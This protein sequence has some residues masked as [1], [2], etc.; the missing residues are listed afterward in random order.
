MGIWIILFIAGGILFIYFNIR[1]CCKFNLT[2]SFIKIYINIKI[3][4]KEHITDK[5]IY[6]TDM[7]KKLSGRYS[8]YKELRA[9][10]YYPYLKYLK[11][12][13]QLFIVKNIHLYP[14]CLDNSS[15][16]AVEFM[17]VNNIIKRPLIKG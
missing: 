14:E 9:K 4:K 15:S 1:A 8:R 7:I 12:V 6:Y 17:V 2:T 11:K 5:K 3:F 13:T 10:K 16:F